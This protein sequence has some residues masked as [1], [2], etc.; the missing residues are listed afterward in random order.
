MA[1]VIPTVPTVP[2]LVSRETTAPSTVVAPPSF[3]MNAC[4]EGSRTTAAAWS[5][6]TDRACS[7]ALWL[8]GLRRPE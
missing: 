1:T 7:S 5:A 6:S 2:L 4:G 8:L 3:G